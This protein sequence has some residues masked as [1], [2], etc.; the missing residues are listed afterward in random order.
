[1]IATLI[2]ADDVAY[3]SV[4]LFIAAVIE[5]PG[6][7][8]FQ[9]TSPLVSDALNTNN[10]IYLKDILIKS[11]KNLLVVSGVFFLLINL[12]L[13]DFYDF[14]NQPKYAIATGVVSIV[15]I[16][17]LYSM[18]IGCLNNIISNSKYYPYI[19]WFSILSAIM[20]VALNLILIPKYGIIG[21]AYATL[22][23]IVFINTLKVILIAI[24]FNIY[25]YSRETIKIAFT[26]V[27][28]YFSIE[29]IELNY[30]SFI[31]ILIRSILIFFIY[32]TII[33]F[34]GLGREINNQIKKVLKI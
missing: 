31:N 19:F 22:L 9:I 15:S 20:A 10:K 17:K 18:S 32:S 33:Y 28:V 13:V 8:M 24:N 23:V 11:S 7:A 21:A 30:N 25:P 3:Y 5:A 1:M 12:N 27:L 2:T 6:R 34:L 4:A 29:F 14:V 26:I 16:G